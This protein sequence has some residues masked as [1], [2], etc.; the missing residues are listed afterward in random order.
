MA[1]PASGAVASVVHFGITSGTAFGATA[2]VVW[3]DLDLQ[4][5]RAEPRSF[6]LTQDAALRSNVLSTATSQQG[7]RL[8]TAYPDATNEGDLLPFLAGAWDTTPSTPQPSPTGMVAQLLSTGGLFEGAE[9]GWRYQTDDQSQTRG[10]HDLR[11]EQGVHHPWNTAKTAAGHYALAYSSAFNR[12]VAVRLRS[13]TSVFDIAYRSLST[14]DPSANYTTTTYTPAI[15]RVPAFTGYSAIVELP[16]GSLRWFYTY[17]PDPSGAPGMSDVDMLTSRDGGATWTLATPGIVSAIYGRT[18]QIF[19]MRAAVSGD[20][21]RMELWLGSTATQG[22]ASVYSGDRGATWGAAVAEPD[23]LDDLSNG[24]S[25]NANELNDIVG[26]GTLDGA[27]F[28]V[29]ALAAGTW[30]YEFASRGGAWAPSGFTVGLISAVG[31]SKALYLARGGAYVYLLVHTDDAAGNN[32]FANYSFLIPVD[33]IQAGWSATAPRV[34]EWVLWGDDIL[35]HTGSMRYGPKGGTLA[36]LGDRL[37][38]L[39]GGIDRETGTGTADWKAGT[40]AYWSGY[41]RR[42]VHRE[43]GVLSDEFGSMFTNYWSSQYGPPAYSGASAFTPWGASSAGTPLLT[44]VADATQF[45]VGTPSR[46][47]ISVSQA[48]AAVTQFMADD[49]V[50]GWTTRA[51]A[52]TSSTQP[53]AVTGAAMRAPRW[54][55]GIQA[56]SSAGL[57]FAVGVHLSSDGS[58]GIYDPNAVTTLFLSPQNALAGI[59]TGSW[60]DFRVAIQTQV[61]TTSAE[62]SWS[63]AGDNVWNTTGPLTLTSA[64]LPTAFQRVEWGHLAVQATATFTHE[65]REAWWSRVSSLGQY[66]LTNPSNLRG[67]LA[68]AEPQHVAQGISIRW[69]GGGGFD[70]DTFVAPVQ[71]QYGGDQLVTPSPESGWRSTTE[72]EQQLLLDAQRASVTGDVVR[73]RHSGFAVVGTNSRY[74]TLEYG[75]DATLSSPSRIYVDGLRYIATLQS[76]GLASN[77]VR[78]NASQAAQWRDGELAGHYCRAQVHALSTNP[79]IIRIATNHGD[80]IHFAGL[81]QGLFSYGITSGVTLD[82]WAD[83]HLLAFADYPQGVRVIADA[84]GTGTRRADNDFPRYLRITIPSDAVQGAPPEGYWRIGSIVAGMTLPF[85]VPLDWNTGDEQSGNVEFTTAVSGAR[86]A[87][88]AGTPRRVVTGNSQGDVERWR[89]AFRATMRHLGRYGAHPLV[90]CSDDQKQS[91]SMLYSRFMGSTELA[92]AGWRYDTTLQRWVQVGDLAVT[93]EEEV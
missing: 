35:G 25:F 32:R 44:W 36:W 86:T 12:V 13:G 87:Y 31:N 50:L 39:A 67:W 60:Y 54:G 82:I 69:G 8:G 70:G 45:T 16:D 92:N 55:A 62:L 24:D 89:E 48:A 34:G 51:T 33:R 5:D 79:S 2:E 26:L 85:S 72:A 7:P 17:V 30:R 37:G 6:L 91:L 29:R 56:L 83:R 15:G 46:L 68:A 23:G 40:L 28:R 11:Y 18:H 22:I 19:A 41:S 10:A 43:A 88:V 53:S 77:S 38:F 73:F 57:S 3:A 65:W 71:Y 52:G 47:S 80:T 63:R 61:S 42:P 59:T 4:A 81:T 27:F 76:Q 75:D 84:S 93:F 58:V 9:W 90:L 21:L 1:T 14:S 66:G 64:V 20:W 49:G 74:F 78:V